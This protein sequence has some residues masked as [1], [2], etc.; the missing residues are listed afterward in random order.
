MNYNNRI[1]FSGLMVGLV[2]EEQFCRSTALSDGIE[3]LH[4]IAFNWA[5]LEALGWCLGAGLL[6]ASNIKNS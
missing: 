4:V 3:W 6:A 2:S 1:W 5:L